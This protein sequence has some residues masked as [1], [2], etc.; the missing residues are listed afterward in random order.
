M[1]LP[2]ELVKALGTSNMGDYLACPN[3]P[4]HHLNNCTVFDGCDEDYT[5]YIKGI[6][7]YYWFDFD[8]T[9]ADKIVIPLRMVFTLGDADTNDGYW[10]AF[11]DRESKELIADIISSGDGETTIKAV[12]KEHVK[13]YIPQELP[14]NILDEVFEILDSGITIIYVSEL[15]KALTDAIYL[16]ETYTHIDSYKKYSGWKQPDNPLV[17][18]LKA[19]IKDRTNRD[20]LETGGEAMPFEIIDPVKISKKINPEHQKMPI[21]FHKASKHKTIR[22]ILHSEY[23]IL[24]G[25][26]IAGLGG[27]A[28]E[29]LNEIAEKDS[30]NKIVEILNILIKNMSNV[31]IYRCCLTYTYPE[32]KSTDVV[33]IITCR[34]RKG[35]EYYGLTSV[36]PNNINKPANQFKFPEYKPSNS[37]IDLKDMIDPLIIN[38]NPQIVTQGNLE[39]SKM[40][41][42]FSSDYNE[43][44]HQLMV[45]SG[46]VTSIPFS[47]FNDL[48]EKNPIFNDFFK[49]ILK[50][51]QDLE[52]YYLYYYPS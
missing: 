34:S 4:E 40:V 48:R 44:C 24:Y 29:F 9:G 30:R 27:I 23:E 21:E 19:I 39:T 41:D 16:S 36:L 1:I 22:S 26:S 6:G 11:R 20:W 42:V 28:R 49:N 43:L 18:E 25:L 52:K 47:S 2:I 32:Q 3:I 15:E 33:H 50:N 37:G 13:K 12:S 5:D 45:K 8:L 10:G 17:I 14:D 31:T 38:F 35:S 46:M 51:S 7:K